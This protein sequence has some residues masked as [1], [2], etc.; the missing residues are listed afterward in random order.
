MI[1]YKTY[2]NY[3][4]ISSYHYINFQNGAF[5]ILKKNKIIIIFDLKKIYGNIYLII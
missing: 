5:K 3:K 1:D 2:N 4:K